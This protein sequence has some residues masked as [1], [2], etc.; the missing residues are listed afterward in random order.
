[1]LGTYLALLPIQFPQSY[2]TYQDPFISRHVRFHL[3]DLI[4]SSANER[5]MSTILL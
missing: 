2:A 3:G 1:M 4:S 5:F